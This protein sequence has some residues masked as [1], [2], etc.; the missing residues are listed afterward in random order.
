RVCEEDISAFFK[1]PSEAKKKMLEIVDFVE[2]E[3][4]VE[5]V[6]FDS[7]PGINKSSLL[8]M[9]MSDKATVVCTID[10]QDIRGAYVL[11]SMARKL[12]TNVH[13]VFNKIPMDRSNEIDGAIEE[14][15]ESL[16]VELLGILTYDEVVAKTWSRKLVMSDNQECEYCDQVTE[17]VEKLIN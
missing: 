6:I 3:Y 16:S 10:R 9:N 15:C 2:R 13:L 11:V 12:E 4:G 17:L 8:V 5:Y 14:F 7:S 1:T